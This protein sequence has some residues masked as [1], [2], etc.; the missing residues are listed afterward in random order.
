MSNLTKEKTTRRIIPNNGSFTSILG[1]IWKNVSK[2]YHKDLRTDWKI[3]F[4]WQ[5]Y[6]LEY[7]LPP[8]TSLKP[9]KIKNLIH[10]FGYWTPFC[11]I[12]VQIFTANNKLSLSKIS[13]MLSSFQR[14]V[15]IFSNLKQ[16]LIFILEWNSLPFFIIQF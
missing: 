10:C 1:H 15:L 9:S 14:L 13:N 3:S 6:I 16:T 2:L 12:F 8:Q 4:K 11:P 7:L 5:L